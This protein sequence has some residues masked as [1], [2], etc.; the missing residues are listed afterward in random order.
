MDRKLLQLPHKGNY[1]HVLLDAR[2]KVQ[3]LG[4]VMASLD[5]LMDPMVEVVELVEL[6]NTS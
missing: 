3:I 6:L 1:F 4:D 5:I 2:T